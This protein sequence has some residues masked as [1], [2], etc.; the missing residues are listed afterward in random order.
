[1][2]GTSV[3]SINAIK[4]A[5]GEGH[6][7]PGGLASGLVGLEQIWLSFFHND[8]MYVLADWLNGLGSTIRQLLISLI[9]GT[10]GGATAPITTADVIVSFIP[11]LGWGASKQI[12]DFLSDLK[13]FVN[14]LKQRVN[15]PQSLFTL[16]PIVKLLHDPTKLSLPLVQASGI[17]L[18]LCVVSLD[19]GATDFVDQ[20][21]AMQTA[22]LNVDV[23]DAVLASSSAPPEFPPVELVSGSLYVDGGV[24]EVLPIEPAVKLG[25][26]R[27]F[28]VQASSKL[29]VKR[30]WQQENVLS[31]ASRSVDILSERNLEKTITPPGSGTGW[32]VPIT[33]IRPTVDIHDAETINP[34]SIRI[35]LDYGYLAAWVAMHRPDLEGVLGRL[36]DARRRAHAFEEYLLA[37]SFYR[38]QTVTPGN[39]SSQVVRE[40]DAAALIKYISAIE[41]SLRPL[42]REV[43]SHLNAWLSNGGLTSTHYTPSLRS[44]VDQYEQHNLPPP[45]DAD[46]PHMLEGTPWTSVT[47]SEGQTLPAATP[48]PLGYTIAAIVGKR[49]SASQKIT[50]TVEL[51]D[52]WSNTPPDLPPAACTIDGQPVPGP[53]KPFQWTF[54]DDSQHVVAANVPYFGPVSSTFTIPDGESTGHELNPHAPNSGAENP[55]PDGG[56][57]RPIVRG[58]DPV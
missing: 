49:S 42:K 24:T 18:S 58:G 29:A 30:D 39:P 12:A 2:C 56:P 31:I 50:V 40:Y 9:S 17:Q 55:R 11:I 47:W 53:G 43:A 41:T 20:H 13:D 27:I 6:A 26:D 33:V 52:A 36:M 44:W 23:L 22:K 4:L 10:G 1:M 32:G 37:M 46:R 25:A 45:S 21:G 19:T 7:L 48:P 5:E 34:G 38:Y 15:P 3:G 16:A 51:Q 57:P 35:S 28:A 14:L 54:H 8:Q